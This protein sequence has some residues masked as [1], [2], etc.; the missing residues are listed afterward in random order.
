MQAIALT[1]TEAETSGHSIMLCHSN[2]GETCHGDWSN[3]YIVSSDHQV[4]YRFI[5][6]NASEVLYWRAFPRMIT[7]LEFLPNGLPNFQNGTFWYCPLKKKYP[8]WAI[9]LSQSGRARFV[10]PDERGK[11]IDDKENILLCEE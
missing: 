7:F 3:G 6:K 11:I 1:R 5:N 9:M 10:L 8:V 2:D 4:V